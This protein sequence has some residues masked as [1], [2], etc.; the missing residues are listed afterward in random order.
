MPNELGGVGE[1]SPRDTLS[2]QGDTWTKT[3]PHNVQ[4][5]MRETTAY[6]DPDL[7]PQSQ[8]YKANKSSKKSSSNEGDEID[9]TGSSLAG[10]VRIEGFLHC[11]QATHPGTRPLQVR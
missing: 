1:T 10:S 11:V 5:T 9:N 8:S 3:E 7:R 2:K 6:G 4:S